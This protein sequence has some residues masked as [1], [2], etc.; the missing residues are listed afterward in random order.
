MIKNLQYSNEEVSWTF[1][2]NEVHVKLNNA[3]FASVDHENNYIYVDCG[4]NY[5]TKQVYIFDFNGNI[6]LNYDIEKGNIIWKFDNLEKEI[7]IQNLLLVGYFP[8][9][10]LLLIMY[11]GKQ[12]E[13]VAFD[14]DGEFLYE[15]IK[16]DGFEI[17]YFQEFT[18][19]VSVVCDGDDNQVDK[20]GRGRFNFKLD[21]K[22]GNLTIKGLA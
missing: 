10:N 22:T 9:K 11:Q 2:K 7:Q 14:L 21:I 19:Y 15:V 1:R 3:F 16:P 4:E 6:L 17:M 5:E 12:R 18:D 20:F 8:R 13:V